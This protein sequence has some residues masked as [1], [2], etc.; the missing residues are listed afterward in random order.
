MQVKLDLKA[1]IKRWWKAL[2]VV[3]FINILPFKWIA[4]FCTGV[5]L[6]RGVMIVCTEDSEGGEKE[7]DQ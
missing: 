7:A 5:L 6:Y 2:V 3:I 1:N 4:G